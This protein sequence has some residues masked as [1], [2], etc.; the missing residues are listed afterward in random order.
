M[1]LAHARALLGK[2]STLYLAPHEPQEDQRRL[3]MLARWAERWSPVVSIDPRDG[4]LID[5]TGGEH[6]FGGEAAMVARIGRS[7]QRLGLTAR[8]GVASTIGAAWAVA[9]FAPNPCTFVQSGDEQEAVGTLDVRALRVDP[10]VIESLEE[11]GIRTIAEVMAL[12]RAALPARYG[13]ELIRR[14]DQMVG[15]LY[16]PIYRLPEKIEFTASMELPGGTTAWES[17]HAASHD[18]LLQLTGLL[19]QRGQ[20]LRQLTAVYD[21][22][23]HGQA[24][25]Q[26]RVSR[27]TRNIKHLWK[28]LHPRLERMQLG[29][30]VET[31]TLHAG[32]IAPVQQQQANYLGDRSGGSDD[33]AFAQMLDVI[34]NRIGRDRVLAPVLHNTHRPERMVSMQPVSDQLPIA[35]AVEVPHCRPSKLIEPPEPIRVMALWPD[36]PVGRFWRD[37]VESAVTFCSSPDRIGGEWWRAQESIRDYFRVQDERGVWLWLFR[38][39]KSGEWF[40]H[41]EWA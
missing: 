34:A 35:T 41:G 33:A 22:I 14:I 29:E 38:D 18:A 12:P 5:L 28:L 16:E 1:T 6:L 15:L 8:L 11:I 25:V 30:G 17:V 3:N 13:P 40:V 19:E 39:A 7:L 26:V 9:R 32:D 36:G 37:G 31:I 27:A 20:G 21:R 10:A 23:D 4:L 2:V 24:M